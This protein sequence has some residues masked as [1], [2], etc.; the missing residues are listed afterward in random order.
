MRA[1]ETEYRG[2]RFRSRL[3][4]R[5]AVFF[6]ALD[7]E[8]L[9]EPEGF[10]KVYWEEEGPIRYLP[11]FFLPRSKTWVEVKGR[12]KKGDS[13]KMAKMLD[14]CSPMEG[15]DDSYDS[16]A[17]NGACEGLMLLGD[18]PLNEGHGIILHPIITHKKGLW[19][20]HAMFGPMSII[21][22][23]MKNYS[24]DL[25]FGM[26]TGLGEVNQYID[27][28]SA[29]DNE[30]DDFFNT[31]YLKIRSYYAFREVAEAYKKA[32]MARFEFGES[33]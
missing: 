30:I 9:Y 7:I 10:E 33:A 25:F 19:R 21:R 3:E 27:P 14:W 31:D 22:L 23:R 8:W 17:K 28:S 20:S 2:C 18:I 29:S 6:D 11:D 12:L 4:A 15:I 24:D 26:L 13:D 16:D 5:W 1:I 32:S